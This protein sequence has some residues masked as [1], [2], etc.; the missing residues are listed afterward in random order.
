[1][2]QQG[3]TQEFKRDKA[4]EALAILSIYEPGFLGGIRDDLE[5]TLWRYGFALSPQEMREARDYLTEN[6][7][8]SDDAI[9]QSL[10]SQD[11]GRRSGRR[12]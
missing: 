11:P 1:M 8:L 3:G 2:Q 12:W 5:S 9:I 7:E 10:V 6:A 4:L